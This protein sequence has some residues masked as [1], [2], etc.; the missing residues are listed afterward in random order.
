ML[1]FCHVLNSK[2]HEL[3]GALPTPVQPSLS[4]SFPVFCVMCPLIPHWF[5]RTGACP[6][7]SQGLD[8]CV[9]DGRHI[10]SQALH[11]TW[12]TTHI[13]HGFNQVLPLSVQLVLVPLRHLRQVLPSALSRPRT[14]SPSLILP[15]MY[16]QFRVCRVQHTVRFRLV[17]RFLELDDLFPGFLCAFC[18]LLFV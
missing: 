10:T 3:P 7:V 5:F 13:S 2:C 1:F 16:S 11:H 12:A 8:N 18:S 17:P 14:P 9:L 15:F 4:S 6:Q